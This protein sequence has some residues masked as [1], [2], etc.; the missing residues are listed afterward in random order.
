MQKR[1]AILL[2]I[3]FSLFITVSHASALPQAAEPGTIQGIVT[4]AGSTEGLPEV[5]IVV[6]GRGT[7]PNPGAVQQLVFD[8]TLAGIGL[9]PGPLNA[10][11]LDLLQTQMDAAAIRGIERVKDFQKVLDDLRAGTPRFVAISDAAG[12]FTIP[13]V[14]AGTY[15][16]RAEREGYF[17]STFRGSTPL[18]VTTSVTVTS[19]QN[20][21]VQISMLAGGTISGVI[22]DDNGQPRS[23]GGVQAFSVTYANG[24]PVLGPAVSKVT[25]DLGE[26]R[27]FWLPPGEYYVGATAEPPRNLLPGE[28]LRGVPPVVNYYPG[29]VDVRAGTLLEV[30]AGEQAEGI[31]ITLQRTRL[32][33]ISG[34]ILTKSSMQAIIDSQNAIGAN[35]AAP[36]VTLMM[37][38]RD[39][40]TPDNTTARVVGSANL[41]TGRFEVQNV[42]PG[43][44]D[45]Y[46][47]IEDLQD[48]VIFLGRAYDWG[49]TQFVVSDRDVED[50]AVSLYPGFPVKGTVTVDNAVPQTPVQISIVPDGTAVKLGAYNALSQNPVQTAPDGS[51]TIPRMPVGQFRITAPGLPPQ[52][53]LADVRQVVSVFD[54]G[55]AIENEAPGPIQ[56]EIK[57]GAGTIAGTVRNSRQEPVAG[58]IVVAVPAAQARRKNGLLYTTATSDA[59]GKF[60]IPGVAPG[61]YRVFSWDAL[62][63]GAHFNETFLARYESRGSS[64]SVRQAAATTL[65]LTVLSGR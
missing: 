22:R 52:F 40:N 15:S 12:I 35:P 55:F 30:R 10:D 21:I 26:Y 4:R 24:F 29:T 36:L 3:T 33:K 46:A 32:P 31:N 9:N 39:A 60:S 1:A 53:Y 37:L 25:N 17:G 5:Q 11:T 58:A 47:R 8:A 13:S 51:F 43:S 48:G 63:G 59:T 44:Y 64:A 42:L 57:S 27:L 49:K 65:D 41:A 16:L 6:L 50:I 7:T 62:S 45:F 19:K 54:S 38:Q 20:S 23:K 18:A 61:E 14:P 2:I 28:A 56:V 34:T